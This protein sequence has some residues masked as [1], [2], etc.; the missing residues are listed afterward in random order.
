MLETATCFIDLPEAR[1]VNFDAYIRKIQ[2]AQNISYMERNQAFWNWIHQFPKA[3]NHVL[4][5]NGFGRYLEWEDAYC[6]AILRISVLTP[7]TI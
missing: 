6:A 2:S 7:R 1:F 5:S 4:Q 3:I